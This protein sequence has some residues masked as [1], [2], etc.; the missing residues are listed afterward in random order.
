MAH[1]LEEDTIK[2]PSGRALLFGAAALAV[3]WAENKLT[4]AFARN[5]ASNRLADSDW[6]DGGERNEAMSSSPEIQ[7]IAR[8]RTIIAELGVGGALVIG[9]ALTAGS[10]R[11]A[12]LGLGLGILAVPGRKII[13]AIAQDPAPATTIGKE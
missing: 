13:N 11:K 4:Q 9:A 3:D 7:D 5:E 8:V 1:R 6:S 10:K 2:L 12:L